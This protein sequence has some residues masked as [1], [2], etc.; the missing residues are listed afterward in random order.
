MFQSLGQTLD[1]PTSPCIPEGRNSFHCHISAHSSTQFHT[2]I[3]RRRKKIKTPWYD[4]YITQ[5]EVAIQ[6]AKAKEAKAEK[7]RKEARPKK[8]ASESSPPK[9]LW[10]ESK[11]V[12]EA[13]AEHIAEDHKKYPHLTAPSDG[14][15][16]PEPYTNAE[17]ADLRAFAQAYS[18]QHQ[19]TTIDNARKQAQDGV[20]ATTLEHAVMMWATW[21]GMADTFGGPKNRKDMTGAEM[22]DWWQEQEALERVPRPLCDLER[23]TMVRVAYHIAWAVRDCDEHFFKRIYTVLKAKRKHFKNEK[24]RTEG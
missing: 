10:H 11:L 4:N 7:I 17:L 22:Q 8:K 20:L 15:K 18:K 19:S 12:A 13:N 14:L 3:K 16:E 2:P 23:A 6:E 21:A 24:K 9:T 1:R 5:A